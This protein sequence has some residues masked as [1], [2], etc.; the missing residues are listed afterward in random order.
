MT[1][2]STILQYSTAATMEKP[3]DEGELVSRSAGAM[4][5]TA[6]VLT[7]VG[8]IVLVAQN[9][10]RNSV[11]EIVGIGAGLSLIHI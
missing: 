5:L 8:S 4:F 3:I 1:N 10:P 9:G 2:S 7:L 11:I 6:F